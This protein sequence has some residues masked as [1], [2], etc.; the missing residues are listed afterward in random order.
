MPLDY[1][2]ETRTLPNGLRVVVSPDH[3]VPTVTVNI[4]VN[5]GS[6]HE[7]AGRTGFAH[8]FEHLMFQG[9]RNVAE[10]EHFARL[11]A[12]GGRLN[13]TTWFDRTNYFEVV[14]KGAYELALWMEADRHGHL[15]DAVTQANLDNQRDV[16]KEEKRQRYDNVPYGNAL[17]RHLRRRL[18]RGPPLPPQHHRVDGGPGRREPGGRARL[19]PHA[20]RPQQHG[21]DPGRRRRRPTRDSPPQSATSATCRPSA[22]PAPRRLHALDPLAEPVRVERRGACPTTGCTSPS[23]CRPTAATSSSRLPGD[24]RHRGPATSRLVQR[25]VRRDQVANAVQAHSMGLVDGVSLGLPRHRRRRR[26]DPEAVEAAVVEELERFAAEG[27]T[28]AEMEASPP[29]PS[30]PGSA[31]SRGRT[32]APTP[33]AST[34]CSTTTASSS[35]PSSTASAPWGRGRPGRRSAG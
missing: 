23:G 18:P 4:W 19:L 27:P 32:S 24:G 5:V 12:A 3:N 25:L 14:P 21:A 6:R 22:H 34:S 9:S 26:P 30:G 7:V 16:V 1:Q 29:S 33:S 28:E 31:R 13:A 10:G 2:V 8:L 20:L 11:Q 17:H 15:L 35:T